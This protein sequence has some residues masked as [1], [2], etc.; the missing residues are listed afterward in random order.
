LKSGAA[1]PYFE[2]V[3]KAEMIGDTVHGFKIVASRRHG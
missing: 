1:L 3:L 2:I